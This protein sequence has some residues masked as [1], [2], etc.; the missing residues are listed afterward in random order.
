MPN[1]RK[2]HTKVSIFNSKLKGPFLWEIRRYECPQS[3]LV[4]GG[5]SQAHFHGFYLNR[6]SSGVVDVASFLRRE[7]VRPWSTTYRRGMDSCFHMQE[8]LSTWRKLV[9]MTKLIYCVTFVIAQLVKKL[10]II[11]ILE[12]ELKGLH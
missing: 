8:I 3:K 4:A 2:I 10:K 11:V 7:T 1:K 12:E 9:V 6:V 5:S